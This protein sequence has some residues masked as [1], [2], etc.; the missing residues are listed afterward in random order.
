MCISC[1]DSIQKLL[2][3]AE[4]LITCDVMRFYQL[5]LLYHSVLWLLSLLHNR[6]TSFEVTDFSWLYKIKSGVHTLE[7]TMVSAK[8]VRAGVIGRR[9]GGGGGGARMHIPTMAHEA[10]Q[11]WSYS[12][13][14]LFA[15]ALLY[16]LA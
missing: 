5:V 6:S 16:T 1:R 4:L 7:V 10:L 2:D 15:S 12:Y 11:L 9:G 8:G 14:I 3:M 13:T